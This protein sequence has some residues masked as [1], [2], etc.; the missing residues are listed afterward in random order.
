MVILNNG[1]RMLRNNNKI[2]FK[3]IRRKELKEV[4]NRPTFTT[5]TYIRISDSDFNMEKVYFIL[6]CIAIGFLI[7]LKLF[8]YTV[9]S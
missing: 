1:V 2:K 6:S 4:N 5:W 7:F 9:Y 3:K 8:R